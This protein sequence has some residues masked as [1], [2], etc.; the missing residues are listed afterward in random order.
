MQ[1]PDVSR[2][3]R[4]DDGA[5]DQPFWL[6]D[7]DGV[8]VV[9]PA[10]CAGLQVRLWLPNQRGLGTLVVDPRTGRPLILPRTVT[11][12][13][14]VER[15]AYKVGRYRLFL[16]DAS[17][18]RLNVAPA[19]IEITPEMAAARCGVVPSD[20]SAV[21]AAAPSS[22]L[23]AQVLGFIRETHG[24]I[25]DMHAQS[26]AQVTSVQRDSVDAHR[27]T[28]AR[29]GQ[30]VEAVAGVMR[31]A[32][33]SGVVQKSTA[34]AAAAAGAPVIVHQAAPANGN[35]LGVSPSTRSAPRNAAGVAAVAEASEKGGVGEAALTLLT[36]I[37]EKVAPV[38]A[39]GVAKKMDVPEDYAR[40][41]AGMVQATGQAIGQMI[42]GGQ[43]TPTPAPAAPATDT[44][45]GAVQ[46]VT[47]TGADLLAHVLR[48]Q[49]ALPDDD[50][51]WVMGQM[52]N[53]PGLV[54]A[55][56]PAVA[57]VSVE[58]GVR[59]VASLRTVHAAL[60]T[61]VERA[62]LDRLL[63]PDL[64]P[65]VFRNLFITVDPDTAVEAVR[66]QAERWAAESAPSRG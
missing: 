56:R 23:I 24:F 3:D 4:M 60:T 1:H 15:V 28:S 8:P 36:P 39:M 46:V 51:A 45:A 21:P 9:M 38:F 66:A 34:L 42:R 29:L 54:E 57:S 32:G 7:P 62:C 18:R 59:A 58:E 64:L 65:H 52:A 19:Q 63:Q 49:G 48:I 41:V 50:R 14:F 17:H 5:D 31:A 20:V 30:V 35:A 6:Y 43:P 12:D 27:E 16:L 61:D 53:R 37:F 22:E 2:F 25:K 13:E 11:P 33:E 44:D 10:E 55:F 47:R 40:S 26:M